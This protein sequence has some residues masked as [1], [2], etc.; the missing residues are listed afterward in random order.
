ML[1]CFLAASCAWND[2]NLC[3]S[4]SILFPTSWRRHK[5][6]KV[7]NA[8]VISMELGFTTGSSN[9]SIPSST[10]FQRRLC[11]RDTFLGLSKPDISCL[12]FLHWVSLKWGHIAWT[13][14]K[15]KKGQTSEQSFVNAVIKIRMTEM[16]SM[17]HSKTSSECSR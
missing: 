3:K 7:F 16:N 9:I 14:L 15:K 4:S 1:H 8:F 17:I 12:N 13:I 2:S 10:I 6:C 11:W 5:F